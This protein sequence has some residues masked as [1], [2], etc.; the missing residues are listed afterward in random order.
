MM[1][2]GFSGNFEGKLIFY[3]QNDCPERSVLTF[4]KLLSCQPCAVALQ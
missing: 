4:G 1:V 2:I 3:F